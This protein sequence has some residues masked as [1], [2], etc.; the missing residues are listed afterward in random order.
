M[1]AGLLCLH[2]AMR[3]RVRMMRYAAAEQAHSGFA[4]WRRIGLILVLGWIALSLLQ[5]FAAAHPEDEF[6]TPGGGLDPELCRALSDLDRAPGA[7]STAEIAQPT[8]FTGTPSVDMDRSVLSTFTTYISIGVRHILPGGYDHILF[9]LAIFLASPRMNPL[10]IQISCFTV[11]HTITLALAA[12]GVITPQASVVEPLIAATIAFAAFENILFGRMT[13]LRPFIVFAFGLIHGMG[14]AGFFGEL[15]LPEGQFW[16]ALIGFNIGVEI[17]QLAVV[18]LAFAASL[19]FRGT[20][21]QA[22]R[23]D[24]YRPLIVIP[25]SLVIG[26][27]GL[28][29][30]FQRLYG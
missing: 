8:Q 3:V 24:L 20:L 11:A 18:G 9:V 21:K 17:G 2:L 1:M 19:Y 14:F 28:I 13:R 4:T 16:S 27:T 29:W 5:P 10:V 22:S 26:V 6:C 15:G 12:A 30:T 23:M 7:G 25:A